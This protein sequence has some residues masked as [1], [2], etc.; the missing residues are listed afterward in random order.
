MP[1]TEDFALTETLYTIVRLAQR[2][3]GLQYAGTEELL[4]LGEEKQNLG[5]VL[6]SADGCWVDLKSADA[7]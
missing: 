3:D 5:L 2:F 4:Q 6:V 1:K 7:S